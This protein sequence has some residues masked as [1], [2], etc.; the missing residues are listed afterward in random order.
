VRDNG[1]GIAPEYHGLVFRPLSRLEQVKE[2]GGTGMGL[3]I[4][5]KIAEAH[6]GR[7]W[8]ESAPGQGSTFYVRLPRF[9]ERASGPVALPAEEAPH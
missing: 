3:Y 1:V 8:L 2:V 9:R 5:R 7:V 4:V 6:G